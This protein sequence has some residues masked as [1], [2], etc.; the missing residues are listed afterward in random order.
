MTSP[1]TQSTHS[2]AAIC[3]DYWQL[4]LHYSPGEGLGQGH[5]S[6]R[7]CFYRESL[8]DLE[9]RAHAR[10]ALATRLAAID[11]ATLK[12][13]DVTSFEMLERQL[14]LDARL[15]GL[16]NDVRPNYFPFGPE[17]VLQILVSA[18]EPVDTEAATYYLERLSSIPRALE[19]FIERYQVGASQ[20]YRLPSVLVPRVLANATA[21]CSLDAAQ[22]AFVKP[23]KG[24]R[25]SREQAKAV[26]IIERDVVPAL[27]RYRD[28]LADVLGRATRDSI[29]LSEEPQGVEYYAAQVDRHTSLQSSPEEIHRIGLEE[30]EIISSQLS[31]VAREAGH[32]GDIDAMRGFVTTDRRFILNSDVELRER[33]EILSKR[34]DGLIPSFFAKVPRSTYTVRSMTREMAANMPP[35]FA[36]SAPV[37]RSA[38]GIHWITSLPERSPTY[39]HVPLALHEAWPGHLMHI[40]LME[41]IEGLPAFRRFGGLHHNAYL[42]GWALYC[43]GLG[44]E[45]GLYDNPYAHFGRLSMDAWRA[46]RLVVDTGIHA[47]GWSRDKA[48]AFLERHQ[49]MGRASAEAEVD[50]Y[51]GM[52]AQALSYKLGHNAIR[53][54]RQEAELA[55]GERFSVREFHSQVIDG[56]AMPLVILEKRIRQWIKTSA[57]MPTREAAG[58]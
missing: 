28:G 58:V 7:T 9:S 34:I 51:I 48:V 15:T 1:Q 53:T 8:A 25:F 5:E 55:L 54:L 50:R 6:S 22:A 23:L 17:S 49:S 3:H 27:Q 16:G 44:V 39:M 18:F 31:K 24:A 4:H 41:E 45:M 11:P 26:A 30:L 14:L 52:P 10:G 35:A 33:I 2:L 36:Q 12:D 38:P 19:D 46:A 37:D 43:E 21:A 57:G 32:G 47:L 20:G 42:E 13:E 40:S 56:G 29:G